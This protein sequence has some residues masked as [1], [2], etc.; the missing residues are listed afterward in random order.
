MYILLGLISALGAVALTLGSVFG[1][2]PEMWYYVPFSVGVALTALAPVVL[3]GKS[4]NRYDSWG[5]FV[6]GM[7]LLIIAAHVVFTLIPGDYHLMDVLTGVWTPVGIAITAFLLL[8][9]PTILAFCPK[10]EEE[11]DEDEDTETEADSNSNFSITEIPVT[12]IGLVEVERNGEKVVF[13]VHAEDAHHEYV[14]AVVKCVSPKSTWVTYLTI[15]PDQLKAS[16]RIIPDGF[17]VSLVPHENIDIEEAKKV[18][19]LE[20][21]PAYKTLKTKSLLPPPALVMVPKT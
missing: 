15:P 1:Y 17:D 3:A 5:R 8:V 7:M 6:G 21:I 11:E 13:E 4:Y 10:V 2:G 9:A 12:H 14:V 19:R 16:K 18:T 20:R